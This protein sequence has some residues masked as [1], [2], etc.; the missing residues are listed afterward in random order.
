MGIGRGGS[1][2]TRT[3]RG[4]DTSGHHGVYFVCAGS[5]SDQKVGLP[6]EK[7]KARFQGGGASMARTGSPPPLPSTRRRERKRVKRAQSQ[8]DRS[9]F[10][11]GPAYTPHP[12]PLS[13]SRLYVLKEPPADVHDRHQVQENHGCGPVMARAPGIGRTAPWALQF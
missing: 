11:A 5:S 2:T 13:P 8:W 3:L 10:S 1:V 6:A 7:R 12:P 9:P 4:R